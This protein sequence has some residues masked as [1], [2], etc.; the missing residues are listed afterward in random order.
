TL[1]LLSTA[2]FFLLLTFIPTVSDFSPSTRAVVVWLP[3]AIFQR[4]EERRPRSASWHRFRCPNPG[5]TPAAALDS[6]PSVPGRVK[7][8]FRM[9]N[10]RASYANGD[11]P[12]IDRPIAA[13]RVDKCGTSCTR[14]VS[15]IRGAQRWESMSSSV[16]CEDSGSVCDST[17]FPGPTDDRRSSSSP[18]ML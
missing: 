11:V 6:P 14:S 18:Y 7:M 8:S 16:E 13:Y 9:S 10:Q 17:I 12:Y 5:E 15:T 4:Q 3:V 1:L 2:T